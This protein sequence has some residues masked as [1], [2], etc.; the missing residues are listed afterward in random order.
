MTAWKVFDEETASELRSR[1]SA[2]PEILR[3]GGACGL[4]GGDAVILAPTAHKGVTMLITARRKMATATER[5]PAFEA[6]PAIQPRGETAPVAVPEEAAS[7]GETGEEFFGPTTWERLEHSDLADHAYE[8]TEAIEQVGKE[9]REI[10]RIETA[11]PTDHPSHY[12]EVAQ[13]E[14]I[15]QIAPPLPT[16]T[17]RRHYVATGFLGLDET[18]E[19]DEDLV[20]EK[21]PWWKK[22]FLD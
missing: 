18:L 8:S 3:E 15:Q 2:D 5:L 22:L 17:H 7:R 14:P 19:D 20:R 10:S 21:R 1:V 9:Y 6:L 16:E 13:P 11:G 4:D 12:A